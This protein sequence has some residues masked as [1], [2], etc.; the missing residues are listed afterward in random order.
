MTKSQ[1]LREEKEYIRKRRAGLLKRREM[2]IKMNG[3]GEINAERSYVDADAIHGGGG[4]REA[5]NVLIEIA[6]IEA[7]LQMLDE[8][9]QNNADQLAALRE[10]VANRDK[11]AEQIPI[12]RDIEGMSLK[13][14]A[15]ELGYTY[16]WVRQVA[17]KIST[18][19]QYNEHTG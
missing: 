2:L 12:L 17:S 9:E 18:N 10:A 8:L 11:L 14:I 1:T 6:K 16:G 7:D 19:E 4:P 15:D 13:E 3:P 5:Y